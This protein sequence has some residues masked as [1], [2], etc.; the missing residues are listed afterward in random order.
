MNRVTV[1]VWA[2]SIAL[3][4]AVA[5]PLLYARSLETSDVFQ[6][7]EGD[8]EL[9]RGLLVGVLSFGNATEQSAEQEL[10]VAAA[11][12]VEETKTVEPDGQTVITATQSPTTTATAVEEMPAERVQPTEIAAVDQELQTEMRV[13]AG[14]ARDSRKAK[15]LSV[16]AGKLHEALRKV[17][18]RH[19]PGTG[20]V[21]VAITVDANGRVK[22]RTLTKSSGI[23]A[24]D[25]FAMDL[26]DRADFPPPPT[27]IGEDDVYYTVPINLSP[28]SS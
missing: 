28:K 12:P 17:K 11:T 22:T 27:G 26:V 4:A 10:V 20:S 5:V 18:T 8:A 14:A 16:Y 15:E 13:S 23:A 25:Q 24:V 19:L 3:H 7:G 2:L 9:Q 6:D 1:T 21:I